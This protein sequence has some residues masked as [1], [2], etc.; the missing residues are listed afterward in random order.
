MGWEE[1]EIMYP[2]YYD[3]EIGEWG[4]F[5]VQCYFFVAGVMVGSLV[6]A[7]I[8]AWWL[9]CMRFGISNWGLP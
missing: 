8:I 7:A 9:T 6:V 5:G 4:L 1:E 2:F 3:P